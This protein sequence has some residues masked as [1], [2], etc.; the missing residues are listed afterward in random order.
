MDQI[1]SDS[2]YLGNFGGF[3]FPFS[4]EEKPGHSTLQV[5][6]QMRAEALPYAFRHTHFEV[7][8]LDELMKLLLML[9]RVGRTNVESLTFTW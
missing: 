2:E 6:K 1:C 3:C 5:C 9:G 8:G 7:W 4:R